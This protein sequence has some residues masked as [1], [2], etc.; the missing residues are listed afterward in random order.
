[1]TTTP[2]SLSKGIPD[3]GKIFNGSGNMKHCLRLCDHGSYLFKDV[4]ARAHNPELI[5]FLWRCQLYKGCGKLIE[6]V[7]HCSTHPLQNLLS[8]LSSIARWIAGLHQYQTLSSQ[9][10]KNLI[11][12]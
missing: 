8:V 2:G 7:L 3:Q 9:A 12:T 10:L 11:A 5:C 6:R 1:M 4:R